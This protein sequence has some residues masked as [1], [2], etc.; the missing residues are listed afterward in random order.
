[1]SRWTSAR[2]IVERVEKRW[3]SGEMLAARVNGENLFPMELRLTRPGPR[4]VAERF[5]EVMD[6]ARELAAASRE[7][8]GRG[9][10][11]RRETVHNRVQG[12]NALPVSAVIPTEDDALDLIRR[13]GAAA[14]FQALVDETLVRHPALKAWLARRPHRALEHAAEWQQVLAVLDWFVARPRPGQPW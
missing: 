6:W 11:L 10:A 7:R 3:N 12:A 2:A 14:R 13:R 5:G 8:R 4:D 9:F 1:M